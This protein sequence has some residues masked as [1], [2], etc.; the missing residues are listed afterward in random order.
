MDDTAGN[1]VLFDVGGGDAAKGASRWIAPEG[2]KLVDWC[3]AAASGQTKTTLNKA[4][5]RVAT[6][7]NSVYLASVVV[8]PPIALTLGPGQDISANQ[9]A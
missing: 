9:V 6:L 8:R 5:V 3:I 1:A 7:L 4:G 2:V